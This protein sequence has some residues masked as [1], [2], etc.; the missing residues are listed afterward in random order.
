MPPF[1]LGMRMSEK[2]SLFSILL[3]HLPSLIQSVL[4]L[5]GVIVAVVSIASA[6]KTARKKQTADLLLSSRADKDLVNGLRCLARLD[7]A[8]NENLGSYASRDKDDTDAAVAIRYVLNHWEYV[9]VGIQS[10]IYDEEMLKRASY[11]TVVRLFQCARP[12]IEKLRQNTGR[13]TLY[14]ELEWLYNR[15]EKSGPPAKKE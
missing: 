7:G 14:Q 15:W 10:D 5:A 6:R 2:D 11:N 12:F 9:C 1:L 8:E 13:P 3:P 4:I